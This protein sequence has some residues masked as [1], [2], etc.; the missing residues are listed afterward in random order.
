MLCFNVLKFKGNDLDS[1]KKYVCKKQYSMKNHS[2]IENEVDK[3]EIG[4]EVFCPVNATINLLSGKWKMKILWE[5]HSGVKRFGQLMETI[6]KVTPAVL[7]MKLQALIGEGIVSKKVYSEIPP[8]VEYELTTTGR[9]L[10]SV[11]CAMEAWG[12]D[13]LK[14]ANVS[15]NKECLWNRLV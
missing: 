4:H 5:L 3:N 12:I 11:I 15:H 2:N 13:Y 10:I 14:S 8:K 6:P 9:S 1:Y 7:S